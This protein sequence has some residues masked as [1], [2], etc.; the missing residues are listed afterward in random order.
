MTSKKIL[1][2]DD[3]VLAADSIVRLLLALGWDAI[4]VYSAKEAQAHLRSNPADVLIIDIG[5]P[6][7][8]GYEF[9]RLLRNKLQLTIPLVA[10]TGYGL[11]EDVSKALAAGFTAHLTKPVGMSE[12]QETLLKLV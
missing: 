6:E 3:N 12:L 11:D 10:L 8:D 7:M 9:A 1:I 5:M 2:V 4:S